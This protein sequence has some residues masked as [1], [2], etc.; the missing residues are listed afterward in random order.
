V[1]ERKARILQ[2]PHA[3]RC[4]VEVGERFELQSCVIE[5]TRVRESLKAGADPL[6]IAEFTRH[7]EERPQLLRFVPPTRQPSHKDENLDLSETERARRE[8]AYTST[9][10]AASPHEPESVGADWEDKRRGERELERQTARKAAM[11]A[12]DSDAEIDRAADA[13]KRRGKALGR[14][15]I[16]LTDTLAEIYARLAAAEKEAA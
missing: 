12:K 4:P 3:G 14:K 11:T 16:D 15:G 13:L 6:W 9:S 2:W 10:H 7:E 8:S 5:I 1:N